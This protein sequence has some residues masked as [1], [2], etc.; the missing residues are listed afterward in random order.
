MSPYV[1]TVSCGEFFLAKILQK[2]SSLPTKFIFFIKTSKWE[3]WWSWWLRMTNAFI[4]CNLLWK[5][6]KSLSPNR[7]GSL[8]HYIY[9]MIIINFSWSRKAGWV[10]DSRKGE[11]FYY[12][13]DQIIYTYYCE[14]FKTKLYTRYYLLWNI[15]TILYIDIWTLCALQ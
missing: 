9:S 12:M 2:S 5:V 4:L 15:F 6:Q 11:S 7:E 3:K 13:H 8:K 14:H 1:E 10:I